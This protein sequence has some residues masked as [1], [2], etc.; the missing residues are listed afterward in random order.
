MTH[1]SFLQ[2]ELS[3]SEHLEGDKVV[4]QLKGALSVTTVP[5]FRQTVQPYLER[6]LSAIVLDFEGV[7]KIVSRGVGAAIDMAVQAKKQGGKLRLENVGKYG[8]SLY[9]Q[10]VHLVADVPELDSFEP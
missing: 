6:N 9:I 4:L 10:G 5:Y 8:R 7:T 2:D 1:S 3:I